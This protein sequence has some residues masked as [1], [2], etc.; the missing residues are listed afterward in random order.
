MVNKQIEESILEAKNTLNQTEQLGE[1][2]YN[3]ADGILYNLKAF[4][5]DEAIRKRISDF[6]EKLLKDFSKKI[7]EARGKLDN[8]DPLLAW[9]SGVGFYM[10]LRQWKTLEMLTFWD[11]LVKT[12]EL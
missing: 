12:N 8:Y 4:V 2:S 9:K 10:E 5:H 1:L 3:I 7:I 11:K 6:E